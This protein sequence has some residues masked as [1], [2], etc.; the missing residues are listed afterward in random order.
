[1][2]CDRSDET[3]HRPR[4]WRYGPGAETHSVGRTMMKIGIIGAGR[5]GG[6][7]ARQAVRAGHEVV[8]SFSRNPQSLTD[9]AAELGERARA[10]SPREAV[11]DTDLTVLAVPWSTIDSA[12][13]QAGALDGTIVVDTTNQFGPGPGPA[14]GQTQA[15]FNAT[16]MPGARYTKS[17]NTLTSA[18][19]E[20]VVGRPVD[21]RVVQWICGDD[22]DAKAVVAD[23]VASLGYVPI[24]LGGIAGCTVMESPRRPGAVYGEEYR[25]KDAEAV[26]AAVHAGEAIPPTPEYS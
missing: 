16:R 23:F 1:M 6:N 10:G 12:V 11:T 15:G 24:D 22:A 18:F 17:F 26:V 3:A 5:I 20:E 19:Q 4:R 14:A 7:V 2:T 8:L 9:F 25:R 21:E 13:Q